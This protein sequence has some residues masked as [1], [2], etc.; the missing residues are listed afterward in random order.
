[1]G[2]G[3]EVMHGTREREVKKGGTKFSCI[4]GKTGR[5]HWS[6][7]F[8]SL[9]TFPHMNFMWCKVPHLHASLMSYH[10]LRGPRTQCEGKEAAEQLLTSLS[11]S[12]ATSHNLACKAMTTSS[13]MGRICLVKM[14]KVKDENISKIMRLSR[15]CI[16]GVLAQRDCAKVG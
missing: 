8:C 6:G 16:T 10:R 7:M 5:R 9:G 14:K 12:W 4:L 3:G 1:M 13:S 11:N 2:R 15:N